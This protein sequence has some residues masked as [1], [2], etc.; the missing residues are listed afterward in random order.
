M[1]AKISCPKCK[2]QYQLPDSALGK[3]VKCKSCGTTFK[4][5]TPASQ[6]LSVQ[7]QGGALAVAQPSAKELAKLGIDGPIRRQADIFAS[8]P[9]NPRA[10]P[11]GNYIQDPGFASIEDVQLEVEEEGGDD[12]MSS[13]VNNPFA[14]TA[15][16]KKKQPESDGTGK[17]K[18]K[19]K[20]KK[21]KVHP[22]VKDSLDQ[23][24]MTLLIIGVLTMCAFGFMLFNA[25]SD[26]AALTANANVEDMGLDAEEAAE[27]V[28]SGLK[29]VWGVGMGLG[30]I[31]VG[32][33]FGVQI[34][35]ITCSVLAL[36]FYL[37]LELVLCLMD[38]LSL[39][40]GAGWLRR[41]IIIGALGKSFMDAMNA[42]SFEKM[43][44][45]RGR[46]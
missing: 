12:G 11:L 43:M 32:F 31:F 45:A 24:T 7:K 4:T 15:K 8:R 14:P 23:A 38:P 36:V 37:S 3:A 13:I 17:K 21:K 41:V 42:R 46:R 26:A 6:G 40:S 34:F 28:A 27:G 39:V 33:A 1:P 2:A 10:N 25:D 19:R 20:K 18:K 30:A 22:G 29:W 44:E 35:P 16:K 9:P 5:K